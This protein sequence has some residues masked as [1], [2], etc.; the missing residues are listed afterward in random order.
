MSGMVQRFESK[1]KP[2]RFYEVQRAADGSLYCSCP[3]WKFQKGK[4]PQDRTCSHIEAV[5]AQQYAASVAAAPIE[6]IQPAQVVGPKVP[7]DPAT[8]VLTEDERHYAIEGHKILAIK[9]LRQRTGL[10]LRD[11]KELI[12]KCQREAKA[13]KIPKRTSAFWKV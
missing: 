5:M 2:G 9:E 11:A 3:K 4:L 7:P 6:V 12:E 13:S 8:V 1:S 10:D